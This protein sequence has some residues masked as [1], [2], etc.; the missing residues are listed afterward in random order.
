MGFGSWLIGAVKTVVKGV[1]TVVT[2]PFRAFFSKGGRQ[3][4]DPQ[5]ESTIQAAR[6]LRNSQMQ[7][8]REIAEQRR[9]DER[10]QERRAKK[11]E[12]EQ[13]QMRK[14]HQERMAQLTAQNKEKAAKE[15]ERFRMLM[16][17]SENR[18]KAGEEKFRRYIA[19]REKRDEEKAKEFA[20]MQRANQKEQDRLRKEQQERLHK[21]EKQLQ[22]AQAQH[23]KE[24]GTMELKVLDEH[25][26][27]LKERLQNKT[28]KCNEL[29]DEYESMD[30]RYQNQTKKITQEKERLAK[31]GFKNVKD[32]S[33]LVLLG[34]TGTGK[35]VLTN[36]LSGDDSKKGNEGLAKS[37]RS[38]I[39]CST[40]PEIIPCERLGSKTLYTVDSGGFADTE[41]RDEDHT[42]M[43]CKFLR[44]C[45]GINAFV[46][47]VNCADPRITRETKEALKIYEDCFGA[48]FYKHMFI[49]G[50]HV[51]AGSSELDAWES[52]EI[53]PRAQL[54]QA[55]QLKR[56]K[57]LS[58]SDRE[59]I[60]VVP[61]GMGNYE[62]A[63]KS[64]WSLLETKFRCKITHKKLESPLQRL[65][66]T[67]KK[68]DLKCKEFK[69]EIDA[70]VVEVESIAERL[71]LVKNQIIAKGGIPS[72]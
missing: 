1:A 46:L 9:R 66:N 21:M 5:L 15:E 18:V 48:D 16:V 55:L 32:G 71:T 42:N 63:L 51:D 52:D 64:I 43:L 4:P 24:V 8:E 50:T 12:K 2:A 62:G 44:G 41:E 61:I 35:S 59:G 49:V 38:H 65:E 57:E 37:S 53:D 22:A 54:V 26:K 56:N 60:P 28:E 29:V 34:R 68:I 23:R 19:A 70:F 13:A 30:K 10:E 7:F 33:V 36:R 20:E 39:S 6:A 17:E 58:K 14:N 69:K 47:T 67:T 31:R 45:G 40:H 11:W 3:P 25:G 72:F 27:L